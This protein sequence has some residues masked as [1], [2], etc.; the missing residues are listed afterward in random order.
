MII[1]SVDTYRDGGTKRVINEEG[2]TFW[3][4]AKLYKDQFMLY[5]GGDYFKGTAKPCTYDEIRQVVYALAG[6]VSKT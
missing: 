5:V 4:P 3:V 2:Q 1:K 6:I